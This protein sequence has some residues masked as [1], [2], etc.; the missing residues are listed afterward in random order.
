M[1]QK[2]KNEFAVQ[3][4]DRWRIRFVE[5]E[6]EKV[7]KAVKLLQS[8]LC[9]MESQSTEIDCHEFMYESRHKK[10]PSYWQSLSDVSSIDFDEVTTKKMNAKTKSTKQ[11]STHN[12]IAHTKSDTH[13]FAW[14]VSSISYTRQ[15]QVVI[16]EA[17]IANLDSFTNEFTEHFEASIGKNIVDNAIITKC[18]LKDNIT[19]G[20][21]VAVN[22][23]VPLS[24]QYINNFRFPINWSFSAYSDATH[25][26]RRFNKRYSGGRRSRGSSNY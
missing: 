22:F 13:R 8:Q 4:D 10:K 11:N 18:T 16:S 3:D 9:E 7:K 1:G 5:I 14:P 26:E 19:V 2:I 17:R 24:H 23:K 21:V 25:S 12:V 15:I 20:I 6:I